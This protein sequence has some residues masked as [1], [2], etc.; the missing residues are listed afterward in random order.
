[1]QRGGLLGYSVLTTV[2]IRGVRHDG[3]LLTWW[4]LD[5]HLEQAAL[6]D[7]SLLAR[8]EALPVFRVRGQDVG[9]LHRLLLSLN[10]KRLRPWVSFDP[11]PVLYV[12]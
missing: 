2:S 12:S 10:H 3:D 4:E 5:F 11:L 8:N 1:M 7:R 9:S 6:P